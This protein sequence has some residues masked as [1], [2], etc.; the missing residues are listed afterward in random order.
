MQ[1]YAPKQL[2]QMDW[3]TANNFY[4]AGDV[5]M[6]EQWPGLYNVAQADNSK[7]KDK[8]GVAITPGGAPTLGGWAAAMTSTTKNADAT[9]KFLEFITSKDG[10]L[11][12]LNN[13]AKL[14][15]TRTSNFQRPEIAASNALYPILLKSLAAAK[16]L[17]DVDVP[18]LSANLNDIEENAIQ[19]AMRGEMKPEDALK[20]MEDSFNKEIKNAGL[21]K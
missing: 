4:A 16:V 5:A 12:K 14:E 19:A 1:K 20:Y 6:M 21:T 9:Y 11:L 7:V 10:E 8:V 13:K 3:D 15:P 17:A 18:Y 2:L